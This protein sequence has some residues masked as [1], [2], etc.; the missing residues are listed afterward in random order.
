[1]KTVEELQSEI[2]ELKSGIEAL[3]AKNKE[4]ITEKRKIQAKYQE[5]D[6][7]QYSKL[8]DENEALKATLEKT[9][10][11]YKS[12][13]EKLS[14]ELKQKDSYLQKTILEDGLSNELLKAGVDK[15]YLKASLALLKSEA[16]V[17]QGENGYKAVIG[18]KD[19]S[20][21]IPEWIKTEGQIFTMKAPEATFTPNGGNPSGGVVGDKKYFDPNSPD[22]SLTKQAEIYK[23]NPELY[24]QL[25][26]N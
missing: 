1:M 6:V 26:G 25:K 8:L 14:T 19:L 22:F 4:L 11:Q 15:K 7:E 18:D 17:A 24:K 12:E 5:I 2:E 3:T 9:Q 10:K 16:K 20:E 23:Q 13:T 21:F